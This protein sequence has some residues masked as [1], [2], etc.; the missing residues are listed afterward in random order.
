MRY[1]W[2]STVLAVVSLFAP[3]CQSRDPAPPGWKS[4]SLG[5][6]QVSLRAPQDYSQ[7]AEPDETLVLTPPNNPGVTLRFNL[8]YLEGEDLP[9]D[10]GAQFVRAQAK[11]KNLPV[12][13]NAGKV[14]LTETNAGDENGV[15]VERRFWQIGF[16]NAVVVMSATVV[17]AKK[18][19]ANV[20][21][22]LDKTIPTVIE[23][24]Q[25]R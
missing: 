16:Q 18:D 15:K 12:T 13:D 25:K 9:A 17:A 20:K 11:K 10:I 7:S 1:N 6:G 2:P 22:F 3:G 14:I 4:H 24:L 19:D 21:E 8:H 5:Q 23:S